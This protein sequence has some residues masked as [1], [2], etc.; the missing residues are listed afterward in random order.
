M[1]TQNKP[2]KPSQPSR[3]ARVRQLFLERGAEEAAVYARRLKLADSSFRTWARLWTK[4]LAAE[5]VVR[6]RDRTAKRN[7]TKAKAMQKAKAEL[8]AQAPTTEVQ[9]TT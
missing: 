2:A 9:A 1:N 6:N 5:K 7:A 3:K 8:E 4:E